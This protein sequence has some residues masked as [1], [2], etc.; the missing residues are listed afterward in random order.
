MCKQPNA[1]KPMDQNF[2][3]CS[4]HRPAEDIAYATALFS[5]KEEECLTGHLDDVILS[6]VLIV[7]TC[8]KHL[9]N[10][11]L[12][13]CVGPTFLVGQ[14]WA[15]FWRIFLQQVMIMMLVL[16]SMVDIY[17]D[18]PGI[19]APFIANLDHKEGTVVEFHNPFTR[20]SLDFFESS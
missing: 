15:Y 16:M 19:C 10:C 14:T 3:N 12:L 18:G 20:K 1:P 6:P 2:W 7:K 13:L 9:L 8:D 17:A 5:R 4:S 11:H